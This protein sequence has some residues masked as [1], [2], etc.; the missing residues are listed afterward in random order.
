MTATVGVGRGRGG[1]GLILLMCFLEEIL[2]LNQAV[3]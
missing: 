2:D 1:D 3:K